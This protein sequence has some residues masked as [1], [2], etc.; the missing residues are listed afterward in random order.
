MRGQYWLMQVDGEAT[1]R[2]CGGKTS[3]GKKR[4][5]RPLSNLAAP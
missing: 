1:T 2:V 3:D 5:V 4:A